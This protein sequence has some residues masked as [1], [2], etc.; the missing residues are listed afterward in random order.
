MINSSNNINIH[1]NNN[2]NNSNNSNKPRCRTHMCNI[3]Q[4]PQTRAG[5]ASQRAI[6]SYDTYTL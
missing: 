6:M 2:N 5:S 1:N 4:R 3:R